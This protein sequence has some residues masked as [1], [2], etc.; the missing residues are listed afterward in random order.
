MEYTELEQTR[1]ISR[2]SI[3]TAINT[4]GTMNPKPDPNPPS[5]VIRCQLAS[6]A[7]LVPRTEQSAMA[8]IM[9]LSKTHNSM[10]L[11][12]ARGDRPIITLRLANKGPC[13]TLDNENTSS[14]SETNDNDDD[15]DDDSSKNILPGR[16]IR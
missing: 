9:A 11:V 4:P 7:G 8:T 1:T 14:N 6:S 12:G 5:T 3:H 16:C 15:D 2:P 10:N 13:D